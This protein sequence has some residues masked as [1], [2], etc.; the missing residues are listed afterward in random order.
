MA[1][2]NIDVIDA[3]IIQPQYYHNIFFFRHELL[4]DK[5]SSESTEAEARQAS[6]KIQA[7]K[8]VMHVILQYGFNYWCSSSKTKI[9]IN[10]QRCDVKDVAPNKSKALNQGPIFSSLILKVA[11]VAENVRKNPTSCKINPLMQ[12]KIWNII[13]SNLQRL[14]LLV[15]KIY[16]CY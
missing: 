11:K 1:I 3:E 4:V 8:E 2:Q 14:A 16:F 6:M 10:P 12:R 5:I 7:H 9:L 15:G 13:W